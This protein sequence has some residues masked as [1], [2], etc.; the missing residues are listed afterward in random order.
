MRTDYVCEINKYLQFSIE[1]LASAQTDLLLKFLITSFL[2][3]LLAL[4]EF[5]E[6]DPDDP[7]DVEKLDLFGVSTSIFVSTIFFTCLLYKLLFV[8][9]LVLLVNFLL[10]I[11]HLLHHT[12]CAD[13]DGDGNEWI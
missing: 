7:D 12:R 5:R 11:Q 9:F 8:C 6:I 13:D 3:S 2:M 4:D 10:Y 1:H